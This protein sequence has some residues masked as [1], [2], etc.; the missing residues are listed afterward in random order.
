VFFSVRDTGIGVPL[1]V[2]ARLFQP[3][4]QADS[5]TTRKYGGTGLGLAIAKQLVELMGGQ[6]GADSTPGQGSTFWFTVPFSLGSMQDGLVP[7]QAIAATK[8]TMGKALPAEF[9]I[10]LAED[11]PVNQEVA[12]G[13]LESFGCQV[14]VTSNGQETLVALE[15]HPYDLI[16]MDWHMPGLDGLAA[17]RQIR[18]KEQQLQIRHLPI[19]ALTANAMEGDRQQCLAAGMDDYLCKPFTQEQLLT[20]LH[21]WS[22]LATAVMEEPTL[23]TVGLEETTTTPREL[24]IPVLDPKLLANIR[25]LQRPGKPDLVRK[26][27]EQYLASTPSLFHAIQ[28]ALGRK[29]APAV[30][31]NA[32]SLKSSSATI[33]AA[34]VAA[35]SK[36]LEMM[37]KANTLDT[38]ATVLSQAETAYAQV[39]RVLIVQLSLLSAETDAT[40]TLG[41]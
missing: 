6:I 20:I 13:M 8:V 39:Q 32:H 37:G 38:A 23:H 41:R 26:V 28:D 34:T 1:E 21:R 3:F 29:A 36:E 18:T 19:I 24:P 25:A 7:S 11:N 12:R 40:M 4:A 35:L 27:L 30:Q 33:G 17:T 15:R 31:Q 9:R 2:Q 16:F 10:L 5:S 22:P 14:D